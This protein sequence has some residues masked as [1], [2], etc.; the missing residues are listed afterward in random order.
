VAVYTDFNKVVYRIQSFIDERVDGAQDVAEEAGR[1]GARLAEHLTRTRPSRKSGKRGR[2]E[3]G[4]MADGISSAVKRNDKTMIRVDFGWLDSPKPYM[5]YQTDAGF[6][7]YWSGEY[8]EPTYALRDATE[9]VR[10]LIAD[11]VEGGGK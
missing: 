4:A 7:H 3:T 5:V 1:T 8:I 11:W 2:V 9:H 6:T 10:G